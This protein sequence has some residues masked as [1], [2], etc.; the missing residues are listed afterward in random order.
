MTIQEQFRTI[1][2][3]SV[4]MCKSLEIE[5]YLIQPSFFASPPKWN[6]GHTSWFF[7]EMILKSFVPDYKP[8]HPKFSFLFNSYYNAIG[9]RVG[10]SQRGDLS[11]PIVKE[12]YQY[13]NHV[14]E[15][16]NKLFDNTELPSQIRDLVILGLN[17]EQQHQELFYTDLKF[18]FSLN[19]LYPA[20]GGT[21]YCETN[22]NKQAD[23][24]KMN[25]GIY[26]IGFDGTG[27]CFDNELKRHKV[28]L[29]P[30]EI[31]NKLV[32][33]GEY[34]EFIE[35]KGYERFEFWHDEALFW[36]KENDISKPLY[37]QQT[38]EG[39]QQYT[40]AGIRKIIPDDILT[41]IT[42]YESYAFAQWKGM[43][44]PTEF[45]WEAA[46]DHF[47]W[48]ER[49]EWTESAYIPYPGYAKATGAVG[50]YNGKFMVNQ[51][52]LRGASVVTPKGHSRKTYRNFFHPNMGWQFNGIRL[53]K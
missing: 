53:A 49:W 40:L 22:E 13:R 17:H 20:Y 51:K 37:W 52:V 6:L 28:Y 36:L 10:R 1:R 27:F 12:V 29:Q 2:Q 24:I 50:E 34:L 26:E 31:S 18:A 15:Q 14:D 25:E 42:Y 5:D 48:G 41:H 4:D 35:D 45:E 11:R 9:D 39:W 23:F 47:H 46:A 21:A 32:T 44:L 16:M 7:E 38:N 30:F 43:R 3:H 33:N 19:P 8:F